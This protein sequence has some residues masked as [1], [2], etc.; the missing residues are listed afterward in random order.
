[1]YISNERED[2]LQDGMFDEVGLQ[3]G[4]EH[5]LLRSFNKGSIRCQIANESNIKNI[6]IMKAT[7]RQ[8]VWYGMT[9]RRTD[10]RIDGD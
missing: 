5:I 1:M 9:Y 2:M 3:C 8:S 10:R 7:C 6:L 4:C